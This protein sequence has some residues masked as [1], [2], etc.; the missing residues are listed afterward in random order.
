MPWEKLAENPALSESVVTL[1]VLRLRERAEAVDGKGGDGGR[2]LF[3]YTDDGELIVYEAKSFT[4]RM[5]SG[6]RRQVVRSLVS[7]ARHQPDHWDLLVPIDPTPAE[8]Q[9]FDGLRVTFPFV[10]RWRGR[11]WLDEKF[12]AHPDLVRYAL[13]DAPEYLLERIAEA[14][15]GQGGLVGGIGG[16]LRWAGSQQMQDHAPGGGGVLRLGLVPDVSKVFVER[17][18]QDV[19]ARALRC[20]EG[21]EGGNGASRPVRGRVIA[22]TG[23]VGKTSLAAWYCHAAAG[24]DGRGV[25]V[26]LWVTAH[27]ASD[28]VGAYAQA[29]G[30]L[31][32]APEGED[33]ATSARRFLNWLRTT[34]RRWLIVLDDVHSPGVMEGLWPPQHTAGD[35]RVIVTTRSREGDLAAMSG[36][37]FLPVGVFT[38][39]QSLACLRGTLRRP[40][41]AGS[42]F[43]AELTGLAEDLGHLPLALSRAAAYLDYNVSCSVAR[44]RRLLADRRLT[45][46]RLT[47]A[48]RGGSGGSSVAALWDISIEQ[49]DRHT[50]KLAR[51]MLELAAVVD[52][53]AGIPEQLF[54][55]RAACAWLAERSGAGRDVDEL[56]AELALATLDRLHLIDRVGHGGGHASW[57]VRVHQLIQRA[58]REYRV[59]AGEGDAWQ[60]RAA[61]VLPAAA[62]ALLEI[63]PHPEDDQDLAQRL[64][65]SA[66]ALAALDQDT[67]SHPLWLDESACPVLFR[68]GNSAGESGGTAWAREHFKEL[69]ALA[70]RYLGPDHPSAL[71][72][73]HMLGRWQAKSADL[74][75]AVTT[76]E[77]VEADY[78]RRYGAGALETL[79]VRHDLAVVRGNAGDAPGAV[80]ALTDVLA[81]RRRAG[82]ERTVILTT[83]HNLAYWK[84]AAGH[85]AQAAEAYRDLVPAMEEEFGSDH[86]GPLMARHNLARW[87][88]EA[89]DA[90]QAVVLLE[91]LVRDQTRVLGP[92]HPYVMTSRQSLARWQAA[93]G[94]TDQAITGYR[95]L[96]RDMGEVFDTDDPE[97]LAARHNLARLEAG[98]DPTAAAADL[99]TVAADRARILGSRHPDTF[100]SRYSL[101]LC[102]GEAGRARDAV[103]VLELLIEDQ[104]HV[105][106]EDHPGVLEARHSLAVMRG[107]AGDPHA[108][109]AGLR[110]LGPD[111]ERVLG[112]G[113]LSTVKAFEDLG[114]WYAAAGDVRAAIETY[115]GLVAHVEQHLGAGHVAVLTA[116]DKF[117]MWQGRAGRPGEAV[118]V[119]SGMLSVAQQVLES[120]DPTIPVIEGNLA[121]WRAQVGGPGGVESAAR[122]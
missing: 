99:Q 11:H 102:L 79:S 109:I 44:Y 28:V 93:T 39:A 10:R 114:D 96:I 26:L 87:I 78:R 94:E 7:A 104:L 40:A 61:L 33:T 21:D 63:W 8:Q 15:A 119:L 60:Q 117:A 120:D 42:D 84:G 112:P 31:A 9:W 3:E 54:G 50:G 86:H 76:L 65:A 70:S 59:P 14:G 52:G 16:Y 2:D 22:G 106:A 53:T 83:L 73:R 1:L 75:Q 46:E 95:A 105:F 55:S 71:V 58:V 101:A 47:P 121:F 74:A 89:G 66:S 88:G 113:H 49:A 24:D 103:R 36:H 90:A 122:T 27:S 29:A 37:A 115:R 43:V 116:L 72:A 34:E 23:G 77:S 56:E 97:L 98:T 111:L 92:R 12:A 62:R 57:F 68:L 108:A 35:G 20:A 48:V 17:G 32:L 38:P 110:S 118:R 18:A 81:G 51:P 69:A 107:E 80:V 45:L 4:G 19:L 91:V 13:Q 25:D 100:I 82:A 64:R 85:A 41:D 5:D 6:R 30:T 67:D